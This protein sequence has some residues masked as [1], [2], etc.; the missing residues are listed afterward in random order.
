M[1]E[2]F[3][4][5]ENGKVIGHVIHETNSDIGMVKN[6]SALVKKYRE[7][8]ILVP[9]TPQNKQF[10]DYLDKFLEQCSKFGT[11]T[12]ESVDT[13]Y[14]HFKTQYEQQQK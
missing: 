11:R 1:A 3:W 6:W 5:S 7:Q 13:A 8:A 2:T 14:N 4:Q 9:D 12:K 10:I